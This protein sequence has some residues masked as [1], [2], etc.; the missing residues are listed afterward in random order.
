MECPYCRGQLEPGKLYASFGGSTCLGYWY[1]AGT[2]PLEL[3]TAGR[4][5]KLGGLRLGGHDPGSLRSTEAWYCRSCKRM[6][7]FNVE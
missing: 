4:L 5:K 1:P 2:K 6:T 3:P 7:L